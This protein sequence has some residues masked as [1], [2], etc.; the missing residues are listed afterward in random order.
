MVSKRFLVTCAKM[1]ARNV[2]NT[3][4]GY[5]LRLRFVS[6]FDRE[7]IAGGLFDHSRLL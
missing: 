1:P 4:E 3:D 7:P 6:F 2:H 5:A